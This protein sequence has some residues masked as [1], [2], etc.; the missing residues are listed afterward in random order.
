MSLYRIEVYPK[1]W[2]PL[3]LDPEIIQH[4]RLDLAW[5][6]KGKFYQLKD[7]QLSQIEME[8]VSKEIFFDPIVENIFFQDFDETRLIAPLPDYVA[9]ISYRGGVTDN[10]ARVVQEAL[11]IV[12]DIQKDKVFSTQCSS[13]T[14]FFIKG[15]LS[16]T[17][18]KEL[19]YKF[20]ANELIEEVSVITFYDFQQKKGLMTLSYLKSN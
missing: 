8:K 16:L 1:E 15:N 5:I 19:I 12:R 9:E 20:Y 13:G 7:K 4:M 6:T 2:H 11:S 10:T 18:A 17:Q 14:L 3:P